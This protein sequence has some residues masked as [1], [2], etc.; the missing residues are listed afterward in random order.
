MKSKNW[1]SLIGLLFILLSCSSTKL[2]DSWKAQNFDSL[3]NSKI[4]VISESP[5]SEVRKSYEIAIASK[6]RA[7]K[8]D[9]IESH[10]QFPSLKEANTPEERAQTVQ[11]FKN[12]GISGIIL[13]SLKQTIE[14]QNG[15]MASQTGIPEDYRDKASFGPNVGSSDVNPV[16]TSKTYV[17]EAL[18]YNLTL[19]ED[20]QLVN[21]CL[22]DVTD[23]DAPDKIEKTFTKIIVDQFK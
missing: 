15:S 18:T 1:Y 11:M 2:M 3:A 19:E 17:L 21:V 6:L 5:E 22:V 10:I 4:L 8:L 12:A 23:P 16:S 14:T 7:Q 20:K 13:T 9:A